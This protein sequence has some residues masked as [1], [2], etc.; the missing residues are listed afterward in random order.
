V[1][2]IGSPAAETDFC[3]IGFTDLYFIGPTHPGFISIFP[4]GATRSSSQR[5]RP[6][7]PPSVFLPIFIDE[8]L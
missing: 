6:P 3:F 1:S 8:A 7:L 4:S 5:N 2:S